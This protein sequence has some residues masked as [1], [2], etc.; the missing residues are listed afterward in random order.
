M[1]WENNNN[2][3]TE[4]WIKWKI[5]NVPVFIFFRIEIR[6]C[7]RDINF[8]RPWE[9]SNGIFPVADAIVWLTTS[10]KRIWF[11]FISFIC[12]NF[13]VF[14]PYIHTHFV[15]VYGRSFVCSVAD[16]REHYILLFAECYLNRNCLV[17]MKFLI[18][19]LNKNDWFAALPINF[20]TCWLLDVGCL[21][22]CHAIGHKASTVNT[23]SVA[24]ALIKWKY[25]TSEIISKITLK[26]A[27]SVRGPDGAQMEPRVQLSSQK[28]AT[29]SYIKKKK[30][31]KHTDTID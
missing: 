11:W 1:S 21:P 28:Q 18:L 22:L 16:S 12:T 25:Y 20:Y 14:S 9:T 17:E 4:K 27:F 7:E 8:V 23:L 6:R 29:R 2:T 13:S 30:N 19:W 24:G 15:R 26:M 31:K 5:T 10:R 3:P